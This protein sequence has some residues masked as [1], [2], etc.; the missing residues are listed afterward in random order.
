MTGPARRSWLRERVQFVHQ[1]FQTNALVEEYIEGRELYV[2]VIGNN[3][4]Q[5]F[6]VWEMNFEKMPEDVAKI[7]T[8][9]VKW[10]PAY[11]KKHGITTGAAIDLPPGIEERLAKLSKRIY[12]LLDLSAYARMDF[13]LS[14]EGQIYVLEA[15]PNPNLSYGEDYAES[16]ELAGVSYETLMQRILNL[17]LNYQAAWRT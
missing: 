15:N 6:P 17:G 10:D 3:R 13:R 16:A 2:G 4:L 14:E 11:Q 1:H 9:R 8:R 5:T 12:R 7:A